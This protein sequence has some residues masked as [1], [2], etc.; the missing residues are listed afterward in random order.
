MKT[1]S[2]FPF[3]VA[4]LLFLSPTSA[5]FADDSDIFGAN[6]QP[7]VVILLDNS[8]S[9]TDTVPSE[10]YLSGTT[11]GTTVHCDPSP[12]VTCAT[13]KVYQRGGFFGSATYSTYAANVASVPNASAQAALNSTGYWGGTIS[14]SKVG[15]YK[16]NYLNFLYGPTSGSDQ[17]IKIA[18]RIINDFLDNVSGVRFGVMS[19]W[20]ANHTAFD[21]S[22][23]KRGAAMVAPIGTPVAT[24]KALVNGIN[25]DWDTPLGD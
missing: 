7:N 12:L 11:Y 3:A 21:T 15:L 17:K 18:Q 24:M 22:A 19:F 5:V 14:G 10:P 13:A 20:Y 2:T 6:I 23:N 16:G 8:L 9:M 25:A 1:L 4:A